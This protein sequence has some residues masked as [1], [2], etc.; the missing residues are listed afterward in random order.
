MLY[1]R[2][3]LVFYFVYSSVHMSIPIHPALP[4][5]LAVDIFVLYF[6]GCISALQIGSSVVHLYHK[7]ACFDHLRPSGFLYS[8]L[9]FIRY[10]LESINCDGRKYSFLIMK[11]LQLE[12]SP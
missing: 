2:F 7:N 5:S 4:S 1:S 6:W 11:N 3:S 10:I 12:K 8:P 9:S